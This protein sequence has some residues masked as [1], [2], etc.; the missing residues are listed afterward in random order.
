MRL[1]GDVAIIAH[2]AADPETLSMLAPVS[3]YS[4]FVRTGSDDGARVDFQ[5]MVTQLVAHIYPG[6]RSIRANPGDWGIDTFV[7]EIDSGYVTVWQSKYF[8]NGVGNTQKAQIRE[9]FKSAIKSAKEQGHTISQWV[10]C[11]PVSMDGPTTKWWDNW[12]R[13]NAKSSGI[14]IELWDETRLQ[15]LLMTPE[16]RNVR[17]TYYEI[18]Q[19]TVSNPPVLEPPDSEDYDTAL[20]V[21]QLREA[22]HSEID[23]AKREFF[24]AEIVARDVLDKGVPAEVRELGS[25]DASVHSLWEHR[26]NTKCVSS[27]DDLLPGLHGEVMADVRAERDSLMPLVT[28]DLVHVCGMVHRVVEDRRAGWVRGWRSIADAEG[29]VPG[30]SPES[31]A[32]EVAG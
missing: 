14:P 19:S 23:A 31:V 2:L 9:S 26:F 8:I 10:L 22:G 32:S 5:D 11:I 6:V 29:D 25:A 13:K 18:G 16:A 4:H 15:Q 12:K 27:E 30:T 24:N 1:Q 17:S 21:R 20:F 28:T 7:G 3:F